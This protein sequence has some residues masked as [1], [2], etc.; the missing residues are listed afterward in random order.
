MQGA[1]AKTKRAAALGIKKEQLPLQGVDINARG[2]GVVLMFLGL[3][4]SL[5][6]KLLFEA[7]LGDPLPDLTRLLVEIRT[8]CSRHRLPFQPVPFSSP[9]NLTA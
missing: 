9:E 6:G 8:L 3:K 1:V 4:G 5:L 2:E 7:L